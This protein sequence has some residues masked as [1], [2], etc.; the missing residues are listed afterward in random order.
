MNL[1]KGI[2]AL[3]LS[4]LVSTTFAQDQ[5]TLMQRIEESPNAIPLNPDGK[6]LDP[7]VLF[8]DFSGNPKRDPG[9]IDIQRTTTGFMYQGIPTFFRSPVALTPEDLRA[10]DV[11]VAKSSK[12]AVI[13][14]QSVAATD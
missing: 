7:G 5:K 14:A 2:A 12:P 1:I 10:G 8:N 9:P 4:A 13:P 11:D 6:M 3:T